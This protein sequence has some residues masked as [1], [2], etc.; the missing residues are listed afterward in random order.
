VFEV[1]VFRTA[2]SDAP[3]TDAEIQLAQREAKE[4]N[5]Y[6]LPPGSRIRVS[7]SQAGVE[8]LFPAARNPGVAAGLT[9]FTVVWVAITWALVHYK[10]PVVFPLVFGFFDLL[11]AWISLELWLGVSRATAKSGVLLL[12]KGLG[13]P[14]REQKI[15]AGMIADVVP[16]IGMQAGSTPYYDV[17]V[18]R[19]DGKKIIAGRS[20]RDKREAE[21]LAITLKEALGLSASGSHQ[22]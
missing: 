12:A 3:A 20:V 19:K 13:Y 6:R 15:S 18:R 22:P 5:E 8:I 1:P 4:L 11:L 9:A 14:A 7:L 2:A 21:W 17:V 10:T 16:A